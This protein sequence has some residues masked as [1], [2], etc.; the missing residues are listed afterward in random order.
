M[1]ARLLLCAECGKDKRQGLLY[2]ATNLEPAEYG[3]VTFGLARK[4]TA[5]QRTVVIS[6][7]LGSESHVLSLDSFDCDDCGSAILPGTDAAAWT[8]WVGEN[9]PGHWEADYLEI[10]E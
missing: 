9:E 10:Q 2:P 8:I 4:P 3:R 6:S 1:S 5:S 7:D